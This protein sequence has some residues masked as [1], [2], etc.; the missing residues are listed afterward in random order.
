METKFK[1]GDKVKIINSG[2]NSMMNNFL[3]VERICK[4]QIGQR[5]PAYIVV[6]QNGRIH[7]I[8]GED[9]LELETD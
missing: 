5:C 4:H 7:Q 3:T 9:Q 8:V 1:V 2:N 6:T